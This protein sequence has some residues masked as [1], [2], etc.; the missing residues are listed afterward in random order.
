[1]SI[2]TSDADR[3]A[4]PDI[5]EYM[6]AAKRHIDETLTATRQLPKV[7]ED[8]FSECPFAEQLY[9]K[10]EEAVTGAE[11]CLQK[12]Y[13]YRDWI[14]EQL[15]KCQENLSVISSGKGSLNTDSPHDR[16]SEA[17]VQQEAFIKRLE[18]LAEQIDE[19]CEQLNEAI[20][21]ASKMKIN[22]KSKL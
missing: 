2:Y 10:K 5:E 21:E 6:P 19:A 13:E 1:M 20:R 3:I 11:H 15:E 22:P 8:G 18:N 12:F 4:A 17:E 9:A 16:L 7:D 14:D